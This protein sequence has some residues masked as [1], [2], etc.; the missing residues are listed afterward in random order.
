MDRT[1]RSSFS[2]VDITVVVES[3]P[4]GGPRT[5]PAIHTLKVL[6]FVEYYAR[7]LGLPVV[8]QVPQQRKWKVQ[9]ARQLLD[10]KDVHA[11]DALAHALAYAATRV[12]TLC[13]GGLTEPV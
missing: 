12:K 5:T 9:E 4:G 10:K 2:A 8:L 1:L 7:L 13:D 3:F 6:G 11:I